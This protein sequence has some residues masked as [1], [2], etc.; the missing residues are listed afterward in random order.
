MKKMDNF[1]LKNYLIEGRLYENEMEVLGKE[2]ANALEDE[3]EEKKDLKE[4]AGLI[5]GVLAATTLTNILSKYVGKIFDKYN[6]GKGVSA[7]KK[8]E[9]FTEELE[10]KFKSPIDFVVGKFI[11][12]EDKKNLITNSLFILFLLALGLKAGKE[13][14]TALKQSSNVAAGINGLKAALKGK[15]I[16]GILK[17]IV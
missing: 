3:F 1:N 10:E 14:F 2:L 13:A 9:D 5:S 11:K 8:I 17:N 12:D 15:D 4:V 7:A 16:V 6:F